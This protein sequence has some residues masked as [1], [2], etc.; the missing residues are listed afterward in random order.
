MD[1]YRSNHKNIYPSS[2]FL[3]QKHLSPLDPPVPSLD[4]DP[5]P[6]EACEGRHIANSGEHHGRPV[7]LPPFG[8]RHFQQASG[9]GDGR[10]ATEGDD[11]VA[12]GVVPS[13]VF[14]LA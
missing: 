7:F 9:D 10:Q 11:R 8:A 2:P 4:P 1:I 3:Q 14:G 12:A 5:D 6:D 13:V